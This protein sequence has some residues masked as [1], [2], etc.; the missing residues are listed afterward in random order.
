MSFDVLAAMRSYLEP[1]LGLPCSTTVPDPRPSRFVTIERTGG[2]A[3]G[4]LDEPNIAVQAWGDTE[5]DA[6]GTALAVREAV[7][8]MPYEVPQV[9]RAQVGGIYAFPDPDSRQ[10]RYQIDAYLVTRL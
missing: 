2:Q 3:S 7:C 1:L 8:A 5:A 6:Y 4:F 9:S 10:S